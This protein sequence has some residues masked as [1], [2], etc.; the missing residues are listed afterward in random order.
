[1]NKTGFSR[2]GAIQ[3]AVSAALL[4]LTS[5]APLFYA[6]TQ[7]SHEWLMVSYGLPALAILLAGILIAFS[8]FVGFLRYCDSKG[9]SMWLGFW[10][11]ISHAPG[12]IVL[13]LLPDLKSDLPK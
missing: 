2:P 11:F 6:A 5:L 4:V 3:M 1:M 12:F 10:L 9:Y 7:P 13:L 8:Y